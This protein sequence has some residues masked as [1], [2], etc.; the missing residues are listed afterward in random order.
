MDDDTSH[1]TSRQLTNG[2]SAV[3]DTVDGYQH[4]HHQQQQHQANHQQPN[5]PPPVGNRQSL[6]H[7]D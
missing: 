5:I 3:S 7:Y 6:W 2:K 4:H 1:R